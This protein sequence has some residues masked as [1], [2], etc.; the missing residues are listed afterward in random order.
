M[1]LKPKKGHS[2]MKRIL[3]LFSQNAIDRAT[4]EPQRLAE[5]L[6]NSSSTGGLEVACA[7]YDNLVHIISKEATTI[8]DSQSGKDISDCDLVYQ[9]RWQDMPDQAKACATYLT[10]KGVPNIDREAFVTASK[11]KLTQMW[12][13]WAADLPIPGTVYAGGKNGLRWILE[14]LS[15]LP[16]AFPMVVKAVDATR[17]QHNHLVAD[18]TA[19][20]AIF[21]AYPDKAFLIQ[22]CI[23]NDGDYRILVAG[24]QAHLAMYRQAAAGTHTNNT[25]QGGQATLVDLATIA[26][27]VIRD[28]IAAAKVF[29]RDFAGVDVVLH[30]TSGKHYFFEVNRAPQIE[31]GKFVE[32]KA[33][34][35]AAYLYSCADQNNRE[36]RVV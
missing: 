23:P 7:V 15:D 35:L 6:E 18:R 27:A 12:Q 28:C 33:A 36:E 9:R 11:N 20:Q 14:H 1:R 31:S 32:E 2:I 24:D 17:G 29:N 26:P 10:K 21:D 22:E 3:L 13:L 16:F 4:A 8:I 19:L 30:N 34:V 25:S 5:L